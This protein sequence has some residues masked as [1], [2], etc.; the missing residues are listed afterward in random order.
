MQPSFRDFTPQQAH[1]L[2]YLEAVASGICQRLVHIREQRFGGHPSLGSHRT[3][4]VRQ[5]TRD[6]QVRHK[7]AIPDLDVHH[8]RP[9][10]CRE[11]FRQDARR[12]QSVL[13]HR[14]RHIAGRVHPTVGRCKI[15]GLTGNGESAPLDRFAEGRLVRGSV[16]PRDGLQLI[17]CAARV[18]QSPT[19]YHGH[20][21]TTSRQNRSQHKRDRIAHASCRVLVQDRT[22]QSFGVP[23]EHLA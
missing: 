10:T 19:S 11:L 13:F 21:T 7:R 18:R 2:F 17:N 9:K 22:P 20:E 16:V 6:L 23:L 1:G 5:L 12:N 4:R 14:R 3:K 8:Q 15:I